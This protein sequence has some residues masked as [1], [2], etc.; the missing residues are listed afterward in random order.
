MNPYNFAILFF[1]FSTFLISLLILL[2][3]QDVIGRSYFI[4]SIFV[5]LWGFNISVIYDQNASYDKALFYARLADAFAVFIPVTWLHFVLIFTQR[6]KALSTF[7]RALYIIS[8]AIDCFMF[9]PWFIPKLEPV[10]GLVHYMRPGPVYHLFT[11]IYF[12]IVP[13]GFFYLY[14]RLR[15]IFG[16]EKQ[17]LAGFLI[18]TFSGFLGGGLTFFPIYGAEVPQYSLFLMPIYPFVMAYFMIRKHLFDEE[19]IAQAARKDKLAAIGVLTTSINHEIRNP[20]YVI[21]GLAE[22]HLSNL[23]GGVYTTKDSALEK[24]KEILTKTIV[25]TQRAMEIMKQFAAFAKKGINES[26]EIKKIK[27]NKILEDILPLVRHELALDKIELRQ[28]IPEDLP[29]FY[30]DARHIEEILFNL[31]VNACQAL[32]QKGREIKEAKIEISALQENGHI[33]ILVKD[34][35]YGI[36]SK[37]VNLF[38]SWN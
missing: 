12:T 20:L 21:Q 8:F 23:E 7:L 32:K 24:S 38:F 13:L 6:E 29:S 1:A 25:Q 4:F 31:I 11:G 18:S 37:R 2:K 36:P 14:K 27:L 17:Q 22:S 35:G 15:I 33:N 3:R 26:A 28:Q 19:Q 5:A 30:G 34:N 9:T 10:V 16:S